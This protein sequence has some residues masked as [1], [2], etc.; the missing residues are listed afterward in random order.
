MKKIYIWVIIIIILLVVLIVQTQRLTAA[1]GAAAISKQ[2]AAALSDSLTQTMLKN[3][4]LEASQ[5]V[6]VA[7]GAELQKLNSDLAAEVKT[8]HAKVLE[9]SKIGVQASGTDTAYVQITHN[10]A[11]TFGLKFNS[12]NSG[13]DWSWSIAGKTTL[14]L[15]DSAIRSDSMIIDSNLLKLSLVT[16]LENVSG[17]YKIFVRSSCPYFSVTSIQGAIVDKS[18]FAPAQKY[19]WF[20]VVAGL[21]LGY[22]PA[23]GWYGGVGL[24]AGLTVVRF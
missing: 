17:T 13:K 14:H 9:L 1:Q 21:Q 6:L 20:A 22:F 12:T 23:T 2:N 19:K 4:Q 16:G 10:T 7:S 5:A 3:G 15:Q 8:E 18:L 11:G 24:S